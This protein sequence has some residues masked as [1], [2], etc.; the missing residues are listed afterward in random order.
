[1]AQRVNVVINLSAF[2]CS[3]SERIAVLSMHV[4]D[5]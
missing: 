2:L 5:S 1:M 4:R 3:V